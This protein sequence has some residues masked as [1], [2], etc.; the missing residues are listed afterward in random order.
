MI[1]KKKTK[2]EALREREKLGKYLE[3]K[4]PLARLHE[5]YNNMNPKPTFELKKIDGKLGAE[6][7]I[8]FTF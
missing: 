3:R 8:K 1:R 2:K 5:I 7:G 6:I 4:T